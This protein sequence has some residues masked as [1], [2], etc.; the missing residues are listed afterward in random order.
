MDASM[1]DM[2]APKMHYWWS[3]L[4]VFLKIKWNVNSAI[5]DRLLLRLF[6]QV[7]SVLRRNWNQQRMQFSGTFANAD[8]FRSA[9]YVA[10][11]LTEVHRCYSIESHTEHMNGKSYSDIFRS[12]SPFVWRRH[13]RHRF[14]DIYHDVTKIDVFLECYYCSWEMNTNFVVVFKSLI[15]KN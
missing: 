4:K 2:N 7:Q 5:F 10:S 15:Q 9:S 3:L 8:F 13:V 14:F 11:S 1:M 6:L 12:D